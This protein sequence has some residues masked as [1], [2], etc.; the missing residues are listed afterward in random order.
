[1]RIHDVCRRAVSLNGSPLRF[2][3]SRRKKDKARMHFA[4]LY[5]LEMFKFMPMRH[6]RMARP[7]VPLSRRARRCLDM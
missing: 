2:R 6:P 7:R 3:A 5:V 1:M 4:R